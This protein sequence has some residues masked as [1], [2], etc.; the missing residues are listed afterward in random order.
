MRSDIFA[1]MSEE[2][3]YKYIIISKRT[4]CLLK[5][6]GEKA[7]RRERHEREVKSGY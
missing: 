1:S 2:F 7:Q 6:F 5:G 4:P 3:V